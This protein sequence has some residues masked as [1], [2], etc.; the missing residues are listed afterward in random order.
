MLLTL[1]SIYDAISEKIDGLLIYL[2]VK[3]KDSSDG[4]VSR[5]CNG[6][7]YSGLC[8]IIFKLIRMIISKIS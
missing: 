4:S 5:N 2:S 6:I 8:N 3:N 7:T 1:I